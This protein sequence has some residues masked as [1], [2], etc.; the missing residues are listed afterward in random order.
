MIYREKFIND[1]GDELVKT[2]S[3]TNH[4]LLQKNTGILYNSSVIDRIYG[5][6]E[7]GFPYPRYS[8]EETNEVVESENEET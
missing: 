8:Y 3:D 2:F 6:D 4:R 5:Y 1:F 7:E